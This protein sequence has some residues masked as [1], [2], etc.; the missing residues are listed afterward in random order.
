MEIAVLDWIQSIRTPIGDMIVPLITRLGDAGKVWILMSVI[1]L[2]HPKS[3]RNGVI[4]AVALCV[5]LVLCEGILKNVFERTRPFYVNTSVQ[6]LIPRPGGYS[7]PSGH[8]AAS[9]TAVAALYFAGERKRLWS[10]LVLALLI[11]FTR[12]YLYVHYPTDIVGGVI[13]GIAAGYIGNRL[14]SRFWRR[15]GRIEKR[16]EKRIEEDT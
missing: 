10:V 6:L 13:A 3:R 12:L 15:K 7:F 4:L 5:D 16:I 8:T 2:L 1:F 11:A 9:F 14:V